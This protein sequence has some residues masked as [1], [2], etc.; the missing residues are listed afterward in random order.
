VWDL[1]S[2][3]APM[4]ALAIPSSLSF[5]AELLDLRRG[6][7]RCIP[8]PPGWAFLSSISSSSKVRYS[9]S[10]THSTWGQISYP[11]R[12]GG[13]GT[14]TIEGT[15]VMGMMELVNDWAGQSWDDGGMNQY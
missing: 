6:V 15:W 4:T 11:Y 3:V 8:A 7:A 14:A 13:S 12:W 9:P 10:E 2:V 1:S 5:D